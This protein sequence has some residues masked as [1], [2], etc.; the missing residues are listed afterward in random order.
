MVA[1]R[2][3]SNSLAKLVALLVGGFTLIGTLVGA[4]VT[5]GQHLRAD[6]D[7]GSAHSDTGGID[8]RAAN[9]D[10]LGTSALFTGGLSARREMMDVKK[11][12]AGALSGALAALVVDINA[13]LGW[14]KAHDG[15]SWDWRVAFARVLQGAVTGAMAGF[16]LSAVS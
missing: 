9:G 2:R 11:I 3:S 4:G 13:Y 7:Q 5:V 12:G 8:P 1:E 10:R 16:G 14:A 15:S 6:A